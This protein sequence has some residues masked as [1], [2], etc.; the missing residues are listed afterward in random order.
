MEISAIQFIFEN[1]E[2]V[3]VPINCF[4]NLEYNVD[5]K[6]VTNFKTTIKDN[7][8]I[9]CSEL[10]DSSVS[11]IQRICQNDIAQITF[12][13]DD[14]VSNNYYTLWGGHKDEV[15]FYQKSI[16]H[17]YT[18]IEVSIKKDNYE[19]DIFQVLKG[20]EVGDKFTDYHGCT[21]VVCEDYDGRYLSPIDRNGK[22]IRTYLDIIMNKFT[23]ND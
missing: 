23:K 17:S 8:K 9:D 13:Y 16:I 11:P 1:C 3:T 22:E 5:G 20:N 14:G 19:E 18:E 21:C 10:Y 12:I 2:G 6:Y 15:N 4:S 7:L